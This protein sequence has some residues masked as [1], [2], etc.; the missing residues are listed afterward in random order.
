MDFP[1]EFRTKVKKAVKLLDE[2]NW[3]LEH[4]DN[5]TPVVCA[6][7]SCVLE[8][9]QRWGG[10]WWVFRNRAFENGFEESGVMDSRKGKYNP[11][12]KDIPRKKKL[13]IDTSGSDFDW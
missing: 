6:Y 3:A 9:Q 12:K 10:E 2:A 4:S 1:N 13:V 5:P 7:N 8:I 11:F